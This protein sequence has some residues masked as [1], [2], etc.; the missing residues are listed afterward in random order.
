MKKLLGTVLAAF[1][2]TQLA[3]QSPAR[4]YKSTTT[5]YGEVAVVEC[6]ITLDDECDRELDAEEAA[7]LYKKNLDARLSN[8]YYTGR[9]SVTP[10]VNFHPMY[11]RFVTGAVTSG[12]IDVPRFYVSLAVAAEGEWRESSAAARGFNRVAPGL[13]FNGWIVPTVFSA[14]NPE[15][16]IKILRH[17]A[18]EHYWLFVSMASDLPGWLM[19][20]DRWTKYLHIWGKGEGPAVALTSTRDL[21][22]QGSRWCQ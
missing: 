1:T 11:G 7:A 12:W 21:P 15:A 19:V 17:D 20:Y 6:P 2:A 16:L 10:E 22:F 4:W 8:D 5:C 9:F 3:A 13:A 18:S 14:D